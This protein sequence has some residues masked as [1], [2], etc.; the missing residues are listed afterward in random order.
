MAVKVG[1][2][3]IELKLDKT[4]FETELANLRREIERTQV[5]FAPSASSRT[6]STVGVGASGVGAGGMSGAGA[7]GIG[8]GVGLIGANADSL[9]SKNEKTF[10]SLTAQ[11][12]NFKN[13]KKE[14]SVWNEELEK[15]RD[16]LEEISKIEFSKT[17]NAV[18]ELSPMP[19]IDVEN[20]LNKN[21]AYV[22]VEKKLEYTIEQ[23]KF[24]KTTLPL[25]DQKIQ[26]TVLELNKLGQEGSKSTQKVTD[27]LKETANETNKVS[28]GAKGASNSFKEMFSN[29]RTNI[30]PLDALLKKL[31]PV[32]IALAA[33]S[34]IS[35][36]SLKSY[37]QAQE[38]QIRLEKFIRATGGA[39]GFTAKQ[40]DKMSNSMAGDTVFNDTE[41]KK[42][43]GVMLTF[44]KVTGDTFTRAMKSAQ[45]M[46]AALGTDLQGSVVQLGK[47]LEDPIAGISAMARSGISFSKAQKET[48]KSLVES[49]NLLEAQLMILK[50][51]E[52][53][54]KG[55]ANRDVRSLS[56]QWAFVKEE[57]GNVFKNIGRS[58]NETIA[59]NRS[60]NAIAETLKF[61]NQLSDKDFMRG[62]L[63]NIVGLDSIA[64]KLMQ[65]N[66]ILKGFA[67]KWPTTLLAG[68]VGTLEAVKDTFTKKGFIESF[69]MSLRTIKAIW[70]DEVS[71]ISDTLPDKKPFDDITDS[72]N[73]MNKALSRVGVDKLQDAFQKFVKTASKIEKIE[74]APKVAPTVDEQVIQD[75]QGVKTIKK[76]IFESLRDTR[77]FYA[78]IWNGIGDGLLAG[79]VSIGSGLQEL[80]S[81]QI[82][83]VKDF[84]GSQYN[85]VKDFYIGVANNM[86]DSLQE[87]AVKFKE[88]LN[89][90]IT[91]PLKGALMFY[92]EKGNNVFDKLKESV[93]K[94]K[95]SLISLGIL[96]KETEFMNMGGI[97][98]GFNTP[99]VSPASINT[100]LASTGISNG[101]SFNQ[102]N[103]KIL[104][105]LQT[106]SLNTANANIGGTFR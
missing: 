98:M 29:L 89:E 94:L 22:D 68:F 104:E 3:F 13:V 93:E 6:A 75:A 31:G 100:P 57:V 102:D 27:K 105:L 33:L 74:V 96:K 81:N 70:V 46:S 45:D 91:T 4:K 62:M 92:F 67:Y 90:L 71:A 72:I 54:V 14:L 21:P 23:L 24:L 8:A 37:A 50:A 43:M 5:Q 106:I 52:G 64:N 79:I 58:I 15:S 69:K 9:F 53:Q 30:A 17:V 38:Q 63:K 56:Q 18:N 101:F 7:V 55:L 42:A 28:Q 86:F 32:G 47:A 44:K 40:L 41:I 77:D 87:S 66:D 1:D 103:T 16:K 73:E 26:N 84:Y 39:A 65:I 34:V 95:Q 82:K 2:A 19:A 49:N 83:I 80:T 20:A 51:V 35:I 97:D 48:I 76:T 36:K 78:N 99:S 25:V 59:L 61:I 11:L 12:Q 60:L 88:K 10:K 85:L